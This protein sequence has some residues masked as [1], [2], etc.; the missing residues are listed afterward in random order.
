VPV[1]AAEHGRRLGVGDANDH[2]LWKI[3][4]IYR[5][6]PKDRNNL[7]DRNQG[8]RGKRT[9]FKTLPTP[10]PSILVNP[11]SGEPAVTFRSVLHLMHYLLKIL[12]TPAFQN[13]EPAMHYAHQPFMLIDSLIE[14][15]FVQVN[16]Q[17]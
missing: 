16:C 11:P 13:K 6:N 1:A 12:T 14:S 4:E 2:L 10:R 5:E 17:I 9:P 8:F 7:F 3:F 15:G